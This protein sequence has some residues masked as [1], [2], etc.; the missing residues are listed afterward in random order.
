MTYLVASTGDEKGALAH[1]QK[2]IEGEEWKKVF[3]VGSS[4]PDGFDHKNVEFILI[5]MNRLLPELVDDI[6]EKLDG[7]I[8]DTEVAVNIISGTG[9]IHMAVVSALLKLGLGIRLIA[10]TSQ[11][12]KEI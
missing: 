2:V 10:F 5:D 9:K 7:K 6:K 4:K 12:V 8:V 3:L 11:G 1:V